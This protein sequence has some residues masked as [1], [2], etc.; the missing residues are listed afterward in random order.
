MNER[1][2][3]NIIEKIMKTWET[4]IKVTTCNGRETVDPISIKRRILQGGSFCVTL[5]IVSLSPIAWY[6]RT[7]EDY[8]LSS[9][10]ALKITHV[11]FVGDL[12]TYHK[13]ESKAAVISL[14]LKQILATSD[15]NGDLGSVQL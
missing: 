12:K 14:K 15:L 6:L 2:V 8:S 5:F 13:S 1:T 4:T 9:S 7:T 10:P 3:M 11:L